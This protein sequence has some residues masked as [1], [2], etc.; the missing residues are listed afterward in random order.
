MVKI[1]K[2]KVNY[3]LETKLNKANEDKLQII[4]TNK[5]E[6][7]YEA[8]KASHKFCLVIPPRE[9]GARKTKYFSI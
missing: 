1:T 2:G 7:I 8:K 3:L 5:E 4:K 6:R 9:C